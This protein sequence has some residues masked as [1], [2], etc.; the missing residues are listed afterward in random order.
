MDES[1]LREA[2]PPAVPETVDGLTVVGIAIVA[3]SL[4]NVMHEGVGHGLACVLA[5][6]QPKFLNAIFFSCG[7]DLGPTGNRVLAAG[8]SV[9]NLVLAGLCSIGLRFVRAPS[10]GHYFLWLLLALNVLMP[11]GYLLFS[12]AGGFGDWA[13]VVDGFR[14]PLLYRA[15][16]ALAGAVLYFIVAPRLLMPGLNQYLGGDPATRRRRAMQ[17]ALVPYLA[18]GVTYVL[19]GLLNPESIWLVLLSAAAASFGGTSWLAY[20][21]GG[22]EDRR[23]SHT[24]LPLPAGIPRQTGWIVAGAL[25]FVLFVGVLGRGVKL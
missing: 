8:G 12:G 16:V 1:V 11:F 15:V 17:V 24:A 23:K 7:A 4:T 2:K 21:P 5:G 9:A 10:A 25:A 14:P 3:Y 19:A 22:S 18:G 20:Y 13:V 6:G